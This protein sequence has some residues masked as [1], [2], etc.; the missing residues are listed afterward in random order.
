MQNECSVLRHWQGDFDEAALQKW[1]ERMRKE[2]NAPHVSLGL[3]FITPRFFPHAAQILEIVRVH[4]QV[5]LLA[6]CSSTGLI[7]G[8]Q[9]V[10]DN[11]GVVLALFH[12]PGAELQAH[13]FDQKQVEESNGPAY[14][15][16]E[17]GLN[18]EQTNGWLAFADPFHLDCDAWLAAWNEAY[19]P[20]PVVGGLASGVHSDQHTQVYLNGEA[21][22]EGGVA[23]SFGGEV[24]LASV[25][26]QGCTPIGETWTI[27][28]A[29]KNLIH[30]IGNRPA[31]EVL[32]DTF[33][34]MAP[35]DQKKARGNLF[36]GLVINEYLEE[37]HR[38]DFLVRNLLGADPNSGVIAVGALP[39]A[40]QTIQ[41]QRRDAAAASED[42]TALL[43]RARKE[44]KKSPI[45]GGC[46]CC[47]N[48]RG[49]RLFGRPN[50]DAAMVQEHLGPIGV[51]GFFCNGEVG[52]VGDR[53]FLHGYTA[54]LALFLKQSAPSLP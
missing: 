12:L 40:G 54:S 39:R 13:R 25:I 28:K 51:A 24:R 8:S 45:Y 47:C 36:V 38:G 10:E 1:A 9:E 3:I 19:A 27:T 33:N 20:V 21:F 49:H 29:E 2:L 41:F 52:P 48:G 44:F 50:H 15:H 53:S 34:G 4:A 17:T 11:A 46:L 7:I 26:S 42:M 18:A 30:Q 14:W 5:P 22:E 32:L 16:L 23:I 37:F 31:Y 35:E 43:E 6:G